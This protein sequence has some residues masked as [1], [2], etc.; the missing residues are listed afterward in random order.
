MDAPEPLDEL[1]NLLSP[2]D[3]LKR[4]ASEGNEPPALQHEAC[5]LIRVRE[6][7]DK[8]SIGYLPEKSKHQIYLAAISS[9]E[10]LWKLWKTFSDLP[11]CEPSRAKFPKRNITAML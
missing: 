1:G 10:I 5:W 9:V 3:K 7:S 4:E 8:Q 2:S 6:K 11:L